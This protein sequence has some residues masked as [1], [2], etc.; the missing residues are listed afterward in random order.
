MGVIVEYDSEARATYLRLRDT[1]GPVET[2]T[3]SEVVMVDIGDDGQVLGVEILKAPAEIAERDLQ[4][5][6]RAY[7]D[8]APVVN[9]ALAG[10]GVH[11]A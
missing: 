6:F 7:P 2:V 4:L 8:L 10:V 1:D 5:L 9:Q 11:A 3:I